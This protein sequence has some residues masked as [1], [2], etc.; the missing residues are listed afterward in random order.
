MPLSHTDGADAMGCYGNVLTSL[1]ELCSGRQFCSVPVQHFETI[2]RGCLPV[3]R[4]KFLQADYI[5]VN[6]E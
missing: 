6:S 2:V 5:C 3:D 4:Y 1:D